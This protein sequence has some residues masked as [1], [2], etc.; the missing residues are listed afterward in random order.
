MAGEIANY[1]KQKKA[2]YGG[3]GG[4]QMATKL[5]AGLEWETERQLGISSPV[6]RTEIGKNKNN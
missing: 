3:A 5:L 4:L 6:A 2:G 1:W